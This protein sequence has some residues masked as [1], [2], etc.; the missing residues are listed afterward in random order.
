MIHATRIDEP[1]SHPRDMRLDFPLKLYIA[2]RFG[3]RRARELVD[4]QRAVFDQYIV[5]LEA[6]QKPADTPED[7]AFLDLMRHG[8]IGRARAALEWL[9]RCLPTERL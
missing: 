1:V 3:A 5:H 8:R 9:D 7:A 6:E 2:R 4:R